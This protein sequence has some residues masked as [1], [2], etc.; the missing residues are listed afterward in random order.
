MPDEKLVVN[1]R[2]AHPFV[3]I[4]VTTLSASYIYKLVYQPVQKLIESG[5]VLKWSQIQDTTT[6]INNKYEFSV[7]ASFLGM[8]QL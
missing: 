3:Y 2:P 7:L 5:I 6:E 1:T 4:D 8:S